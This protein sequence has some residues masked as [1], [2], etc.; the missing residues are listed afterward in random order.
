MFVRDDLLDCADV[1]EEEAEARSALQDEAEPRGGED[2]G[3]S[4]ATGESGIKNKAARDKHEPITKE[5]S[6]TLTRCGIVSSAAVKVV[7]VPGGHVMTVAFAIGLRVQELKLQLAA[8]LR[9]PAEVLQISLDGASRVPPPLS[10]RRTAV[11]YRISVVEPW[12]ISHEGFP[13]SSDNV[14]P[15]F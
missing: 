12:F 4:T 3:S 2:A 10:H 15:L 1:P 5:C 6:I 11:G 9:V 7:L 8:E 14:E 13:V